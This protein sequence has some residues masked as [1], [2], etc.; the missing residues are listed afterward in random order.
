MGSP[1]Q[2]LSAPWFGTG[3]Y[4]QIKRVTATSPGHCIGKP[5][6]PKPPAAQMTRPLCACYGLVPP[7]AVQDMPLGV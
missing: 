3:S 1:R 2:D 7:M 6:G 4:R 5:A